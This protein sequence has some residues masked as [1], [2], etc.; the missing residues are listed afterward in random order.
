MSE[1][2]LSVLAAPRCK[3]DRLP[4]EYRG[5]SLM[6]NTHPSRITIGP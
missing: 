2:T 1:V 4:N 5:T 6:R 3:R